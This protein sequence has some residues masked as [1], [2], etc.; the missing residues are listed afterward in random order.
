MISL[1]KALLVFLTLLVATGAGAEAA[2]PSPSAMEEAFY[3]RNWAEVDR[4]LAQGGLSFREISLGANGLWAQGRWSHSLD[5]MRSL[6]GT[7][8]QE[9]APYAKLLQVLALERLGQ[10]SEGHGQALGLYLSDPPATVKY[11]SAY[12]LSRITTNPDE[13]E[14]WLHRMVGLAVTPSQQRTALMALADRKKLTSSEALALLRLQPRQGDALTLAQQAPASA[15]RDYRVGYS[16]YLAGRHSEAVQWLQRLDPQG[17][18]GEPGSY[19]LALSLARLGRLAEAQK[20]YQSLV[21]RPGG[22][23]YIRSLRQLSRMLEGSAG[24]QALAV[25]EQVAA[26]EEPQKAAAAL[27]F[28]AGSRHYSRRDQA[29]QELLRR[30]P[31]SRQA[32]EILW[33][34][35]WNCWL[36]QDYSAALEFWTQG[37]NSGGQDGDRLLYW[38]IQALQKLGR[39]SEAGELLEKLRTEHPMSFYSFQASPGGSLEI[40]DEDLPQDFADRHVTELERWGFMV[41]AHLE[42]SERTDSASKI[43]A[44]FIARWLGQE[45]QAYGHIRGILPRYLAAN[46]VA[47]PLLEMAYPRPYRQQ[48]ETAAS[49]WGLD[50]LL[51]WAVMRQESSFDPQARS[52]SGATGL[53]QL[54]AGTASDE[55]RRSGLSSYSLYDVEDNI[56]LGASHLRWLRQRIGPIQWILAAYNAGSGNLNR[57]NELRGDWPM[58]SWIE[59]IPFPETRNYVKIVMANYQIYQRLYCSQEGPSGP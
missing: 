18:Y 29:R 44:A 36:Q 19:Y 39:Q 37:W 53:M 45:G 32:Q 43:S 4:L 30:F 3:S 52:N 50:P 26:G 21:F 20:I 40:V 22:D 46:P 54:M 10:R 8:P 12:A 27:S 34:Q 31:Q 49:R 2:P 42:L 13:A 48:V 24:A 9:V 23:Y 41:H 11:Y 47:R 15:E 58:D 17:P 38:R 33:D 7:Y 28:L 56:L 5:L 57:W 35:G 59:A 51:I 1:I 14:K 16:H 25:L 55:A 6:E